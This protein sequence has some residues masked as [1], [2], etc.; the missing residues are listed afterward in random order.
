MTGRHIIGYV[1]INLRN[2]QVNHSG[3]SD[4]IS[5]LDLPVYCQRRLIIRNRH[6]KRGKSKKITVSA[7]EK[8]I[9]SVPL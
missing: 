7:I 4:A 2:S 8:R 3:K 9:S 1:H 5:G 6:N